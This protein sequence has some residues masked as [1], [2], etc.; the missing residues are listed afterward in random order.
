MATGAL[1]MLA[2]CGGGGGDDDEFEP[3][4][5]P[6]GPAGMLD[7]YVG[8]YSACDLNHTRFNLVVTSEVNRLHGFKRENVTY[9]NADCTGSVLGTHAWSAPAQLEYLSAS[10]VLVRSTELPGN[11]RVD[12]ARILMSNVRF[13]VEGP[14][15]ANDCITYP[16]GTI[17]YDTKTIN[18]DGEIALY[19]SGSTLYVMAQNILVSEHGVP[20]HRY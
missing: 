18:G 7:K 1:A 6:A 15:V 14:A 2:A 12:K 16:K 17:C 13:K 10:D 8:S 19:L 4:G 5:P 11:L 3:I 9:E 20:V